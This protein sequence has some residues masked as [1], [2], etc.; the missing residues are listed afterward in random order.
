VLNPPLFFLGCKP[1]TREKSSPPPSPP[2]NVSPP[3]VFFHPYFLLKSNL[4]VDSTR[5]RS[6]DHSNPPPM[7]LFA[8]FCF[9]MWPSP[10]AVGVFATP[11]EFVARSANGFRDPP[12]PVTLVGAEAGGFRIRGRQ[13]SQVRRSWI[14]AWRCRFLPFLHFGSF[15]PS[16]LSCRTQGM[17]RYISPFLFPSLGSLSTVTTIGASVT[18]HQLFSPPLRPPPLNAIPCCVLLPFRE[19]VC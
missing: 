15:P 10:L 3:A 19:S 6:P 16:S 13:R 5:R 7:P 2:L 8:H 9:L 1:P 18:G 11:L 12:F 17:R 14:P 4:S